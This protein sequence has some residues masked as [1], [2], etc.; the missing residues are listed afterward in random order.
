MPHDFKQ[1]EF[2]PYIHQLKCHMT[3][4][5]WNLAGTSTDLNAT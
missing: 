3:S 2:V 5:N 1:L 4:D